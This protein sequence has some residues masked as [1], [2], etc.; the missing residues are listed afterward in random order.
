MAFYWNAF[1]FHSR[2]DEN[3]LTEAHVKISSLQDEIS[4]LKRVHE[5][6]ISKLEKNDWASITRVD[7]S[8][9]QKSP[10][11]SEVE[12]TE[13][14]QVVTMDKDAA[15]SGEYEVP[16]GHSQK[17][18]IVKNKGNEKDQPISDGTIDESNSGAAATSTSTSSSDNPC[19]FSPE[20]KIA[21]NAG[22]PE[23]YMPK[24]D[25][26]KHYCQGCDT[27]DKRLYT[28]YTHIRQKHTGP[29][30]CKACGQEYFSAARIKEH[31]KTNHWGPLSLYFVLS[32]VL[33]SV[34][35]QVVHSSRVLNV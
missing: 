7:E 32:L 14:Q 13:L 25:G 8:W 33:D 24:S 19:S 2:L 18:N 3:A 11:S 1:S 17:G 10:Q 27:V 23:K 16:I 31:M 12:H 29:F 35:T 15:S 5:E 26:K 20:D 4:E 21:S 9:R 30:R 28:M 22:I 6:K 34:C